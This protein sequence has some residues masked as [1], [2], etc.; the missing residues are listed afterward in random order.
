MYQEKIYII[1]KCILYFCL[2]D[3]IIS[4]HLRPVFFC[5]NRA[6]C[7]DSQH[8]HSQIDCLWK[9]RDRQNSSL[10]Q[11][12]MIFSFSQGN[13][14]FKQRPIDEH[15]RICSAMESHIEEIIQM[16]MIQTMFQL[17]IW[18]CLQSKPYH[19]FVITKE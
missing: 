14:N 18:L 2:F 4:L 15:A 16:E 3:L 19:S 12:H 5:L 9:H 11:F 6:L 17:Y 8:Y 1:F 13:G 7:S 10:E